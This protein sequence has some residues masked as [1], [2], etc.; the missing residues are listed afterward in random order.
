MLWDKRGRRAEELPLYRLATSVLL[1]GLLAEWLLPWSDSGQWSAVYHIGPLLTVIACIMTVGLFRLNG[2]VSLLVHTL[3]VL[4]SLAWL[5]KGEG[6][7]IQWLTAFPGLLAEQLSVIA[8]SELWAMSGELR[9]LILFVGWAMLAPALQAL[10]WQRQASLGLAGI[11]LLYLILLH[12][13]LGMD[14]MGGLLRV[15]AEGLL[16]AAL[17]SIPRVRRIMDAS[18]MKMKQ[19]GGKWLGGALFLTVTVVGLSLLLSSG[20]ESELPPAKWTAAFSE[21][22]SQEVSSWGSGASTTTVQS[23]R[24]EQLGSSLTGYGFDDTEL[25][26]AIADDDTT[27]FW[28]Y[29]PVKA[30]WRGE[31]KSVY[32][33]RGWSHSISGLTLLPISSDGATAAVE[34]MEGGNEAGGGKE[35]VLEAAASPEQ[36]WISQTVLW[37]MPR[38]AMPLLMSGQGGRA[39]E[40]VAADPRRKLGSYLENA[41]S[42]TLYAHTETVKLESYSVKSRLPVADAD[43]L[44][45]L[46][47]RGGFVSSNR[48]DA[49]D[50]WT[51]AELEPFLQLPESLPPRVAALAAEVSGGG[52]TSRYDRVKAIEQYLE[53][54]YAY[55]KTAS[56]PPPAGADFVDH[57]LF[58]QKSGYCVH[59]STAMVVMLRAEGIPARW[60]KGFASGTPAPDGEGAAAK[61]LG[62]T[63][64]GDASLYEVKNS[65]AHAWVEVYFPGAGWVPFDPTPGFS[66]GEAVAAAAMSGGG[67]EAAAAEA[68]AA[69]RPGGEA[70]DAGLAER[71]EA[72][73]EVGAAAIAR[74]ARGLSRGASDAAEAAAAAPA[75]AAAALCAALA[76]AC[77]AVAFA[78]R[79]RL[80]LALAL[81]R[82]RKA[83]AELATV[84][85]RLGAAGDDFVPARSLLHETQHVY[86]QLGEIG[87][88]I[89]EVQL[90]D[91]VEPLSR[92]TK[93]R[94]A[95]LAA[96]EKQRRELIGAADALFALLRGRHF[97][98]YGTGDGMDN[99]HAD[100][101]RWGSSH[102]M[103]SR[104]EGRR[105]AASSLEPLNPAVL[106]LREFALAVSEIWDSEDRIKLD[107]LVQLREEAVF[108]LPGRLMDAPAYEE[109]KPLCLALAALPKNRQL[110]KRTLP[111]LTEDT[112]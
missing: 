34:E 40:I 58:E 110:L 81:R 90:A 33:G 87:S 35:S 21:Q 26:G 109:L 72:A 111:V 42:G 43:V 71:M 66:G 2:A 80:R 4:F 46:D 45:S 41:T 37:E 30:Y 29:S 105:V 23:M 65:D 39:T 57:F 8:S 1:F 6:S 16:L 10:I 14:V 100:R 78:Q 97:P 19:S 53:S 89:A 54:A 59:F 15:S 28:G 5:F 103:E 96:S 61:K 62:I 36:Q 13:W 44:R 112:P 22:L 91:L 101:M 92:R 98:R 47:G 73:A 77:A 50:A 60:V 32:D 52:V 106:T 93:S 99:L 38:A 88:A 82:Y 75:A 12:V 49:R 74:F 95:L 86:G 107:R 68:G 69:A 11:T 51:E 24:G 79:K 31:T 63:L 67:A 104:L 94:A 20:K 48:S 83:C 55:S 102:Q 3:L 17:V 76:A 18:A 27:A 9:T 108:G 56:E 70:S 25:G 7:A 85:P 84:A 64:A